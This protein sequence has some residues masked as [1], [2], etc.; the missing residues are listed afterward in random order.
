[1]CLSVYLG[2]HEPLQTRRVQIGA[3]GIEQANWAPPALSNFPFRYYLGRRGEDGELGCSCLLAQHVEW[4]E[5]GPSVCLDELY[6]EEQCPFRALRG[7]V[8]DAQRSAKP[9]VIA[10]DDSAGLPMDCSD[11][12][13]DHFVVSVEMIKPSSYLFADPVASFPWRVM[14]LTGSTLP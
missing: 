2:S 14:Y 11:D 9:V 6:S 12:D 4:D 7:Y 13:Y 1:M 10:C 3:L 5:H 8:S